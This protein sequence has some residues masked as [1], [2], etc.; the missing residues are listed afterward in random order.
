MSTPT[1]AFI[2][3]GNMARAII[4]G[5][6]EKGHPPE[7]VWASAPNDDH[8]SALRTDFGIQTTTDNDECAARADVLVLAVKPQVMKTVCEAL[9]PT[10][11]QHQPL[12]VSIAAGLDTDTLNTW[13]G[14]KQALIRCMPNTPSLVGEGVSALF[15]TAEVSEAQQTVARQLFDSIGL[16]VWLEDEAQMH[17]VTGLSGSGPA[18]FFLILEA[19]ENAATEAGLPAETAR[20]L[21]IQTMGGAA[22][23]AAT[24]K[25]DP[26]TLKQNVMSPGGTTERAIQTFE[27]G[28]LR[29]LIR[30]AYGAAVTHSEHMAE[31]LKQS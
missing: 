8:L 18:Y 3:A 1:L 25:D 2:G 7:Q 28:G 11:R 20:K 9:S 14:G 30:N 31:Q 19:L 16:T 6:L 5:L 21:A 12:V 4:G 27:D 24:G 23:M 17:A 22:N 13:L 29:A 15:A 26:A 10:V